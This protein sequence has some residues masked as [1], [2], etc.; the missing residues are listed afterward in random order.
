M[1]LCIYYFEAHYLLIMHE[2]DLK[3]YAA[4]RHSSKER[5]NDGYGYDTAGIGYGERAEIVAE[6][7]HT[8]TDM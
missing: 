5:A 4:K 8:A 3:G 2:K 6:R 7:G 1:I